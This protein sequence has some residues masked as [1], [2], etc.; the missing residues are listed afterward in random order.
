MFSEAMHFTNPYGRRWEEVVKGLPSWARKLEEF[1]PAE[2][3]AALTALIRQKEE[4]PTLAG[5]LKILEKH[6][7][8]LCG[9]VYSAL[10]AESR[11]GRFI[12]SDEWAF[13]NAYESQE[14]GKAKKN[15]SLG[16]NQSTQNR[17]AE[18]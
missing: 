11:N 14:V 7:E 12:T 15:D 13:I 8:P 17:L 2:I 6:P 10:K 9:R 3:H 1:S 16:A 4:F 5:V 18:K